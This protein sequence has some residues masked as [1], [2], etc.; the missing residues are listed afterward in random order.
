LYEIV[1]VDPP[2]A[3]LIHDGA[4]EAALV[5]HARANGPSLLDEGIAAVRS[6]ET[7]VEEVARVTRDEAG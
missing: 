6:G 3:A 1:A 2:M 4:P 7:T 5:A